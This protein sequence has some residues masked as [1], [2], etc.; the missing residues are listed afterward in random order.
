MAQ[1]VGWLLF[2]YLAVFPLNL[3]RDLANHFF[4]FLLHLRLLPEV[5][6]TETANS[7][8]YGNFGSQEQHLLVLGSNESNH[9]TTADLIQEL[10]L[11]F[12]P[13]ELMVS[14]KEVP[15]SEGAAAPANDRQGNLQKDNESTWARREDGKERQ[16]EASVQ[17]YREPPR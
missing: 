8:L 11:L 5:Y 7:A 17:E 15:R 9:G 16:R 13:G 1:S 6:E 12:F 2:Q 4:F 14:D 10:Y 3:T